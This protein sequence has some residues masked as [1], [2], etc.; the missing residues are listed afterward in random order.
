MAE[1]DTGAGSVRP[2]GASP[3]GRGN[4]PVKPQTMWELVLLSAFLPG[5]GQFANG[6]RG[7]GLLFVIPSAILF[8]DIT[9]RTFIM[10]QMVFAPVMA[11]EPLFVTDDAFKVLMSLFPL[12]GIALL[13]W[14]AALVDTILVG[15]RLIKQREED[16]SK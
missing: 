12:L 1:R 8:V 6:Q 14:A 2:K 5:A 9:V 11:G 4:A 16:A 7:K 10:A 15:Q 3:P 13:I